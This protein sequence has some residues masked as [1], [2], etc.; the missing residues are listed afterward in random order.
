MAEPNV[1]AALYTKV[2][3]DAGV[4]ALVGTRVYYGQA[5]AGSEMPRV[6]FA[7]AGGGEQNTCPR[8]MINL[9]YRVEAIAETKA[10]AVAL[11]SAISSALHEQELTISGWQNYVLDRENTYRPPVENLE[12]RQVYRVGAYYRIRLVKL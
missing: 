3:G 2:T 6:I 4:A 7:W 8:R 12:G 10:G 9:V 5:P 1:D 11:D